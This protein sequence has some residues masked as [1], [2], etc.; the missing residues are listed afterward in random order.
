VLFQPTSPGAAGIARRIRRRLVVRGSR[1]RR[2][3]RRSP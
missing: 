2:A 1:R 3:A